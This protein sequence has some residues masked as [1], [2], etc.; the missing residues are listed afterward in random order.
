VAGFGL[1]PPDFEARTVI[2][3]DLESNP[4]LLG[5]GWIGGTT[6][7]FVSMAPD[8]L[9]VDLTDARY[10]LTIRGIPVGYLAGLDSVDLLPGVAP[11]M[12]GVTV[13]GSRELRLFRT[14]GA[15]VDA[16]QADLERGARMRRI[17]AGG[18]Y[19]AESAELSTRRAT[20]EL[21]AP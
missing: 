17:V 16:L 11:T 12:Y 19:N 5:I 1:A 18:R 21:S 14:F 10:G 8:R 2:D 15:L 6:N 13:R 4:A 7:P 20:F 3:V 9:V